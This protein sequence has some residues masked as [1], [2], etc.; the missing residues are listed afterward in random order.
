GRRG[1]CLAR[2]RSRELKPEPGCGRGGRSGR[3]ARAPPAAPRAAPGATASA[4]PAPPPPPGGGRGLPALHAA[5]NQ[6]GA[7]LQVAG[8][9]GA[10][11]A[12]ARGQRRQTL[13]QNFRHHARAGE[14]RHCG[15][16]GRPGAEQPRLLLGGLSARGQTLQGQVQAHQPHPRAHRREALPLPVP[17]LRQG[18]RALRE[19]QDPQAHS[20][21][22]SIAH[23]G[24]ALA[25]LLAESPARPQPLR[26]DRQ[27]APAATASAAAREQ[28]KQQE[29]AQDGRQPSRAQPREEKPFKCEF[30]GCDRKFANSSDRKKHSHVHTSDKP[31]YCKIRGCD[32]SYTHPSSLRKHMKIHCKSPPPSPGALGY[33]SVGTPVGDTL[34]P[35]LDPTRS[36]S[37]TLSPQVTNLNEWYV[38][39]ASG[40]PSHLHTPSSNGTTSESEDE[41]MYGNPEVVRTIH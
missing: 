41:E 13:L 9:G 30:D 31:Y 18:L 5:A 23:T 27:S 19:P 1:R 34:S 38:C 36:R 28:Q 35:V 17:G 10:G 16:R 20:Y 8:P 29:G 2:L 37:S 11:R 26:R 12:A 21:S 22:N 33:S 6:A 32:K 24:S 3:G 39:Q 15:A 7:H 40:A 14:P 4:A 25:S